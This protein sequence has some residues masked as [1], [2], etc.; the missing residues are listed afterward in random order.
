MKKPVE[1]I[2]KELEE[3]FADG[4]LEDVFID[5]EYIDENKGRAIVSK[6]YEYVDI[7]FKTMMK[8]REIFNGEFNIDSEQFNGCETCDYG[9]RYIKTFYFEINDNYEEKD[10]NANTHDN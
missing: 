1:V 9:S 8:L 7:Q 3:L 5:V 10:K 6:M 4:S 2:E